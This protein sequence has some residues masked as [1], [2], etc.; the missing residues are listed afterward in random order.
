MPAQKKEIVLTGQISIMDE[1]IGSPNRGAHKKAQE[2]VG[3]GISTMSQR[4]I[5]SAVMDDAAKGME[6]Q[7]DGEKIM[8][9]FSKKGK[10]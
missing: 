2:N 10:S 4:N 8:S 9:I 5:L 1:L 3:M 6:G 7:G